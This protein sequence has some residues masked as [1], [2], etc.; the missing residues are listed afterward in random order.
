MF[1]TATQVHA[2]QVATHAPAIQAVVE[3]VFNTVDERDWAACQALFT[4]TVTADYKSLSGQPAISLPAATLIAGWKQVLPGF[5]GTQ[6]MLSNFRTRIL[7]E[8]TA[9]VRFYGQAFHFLPNSKGE[10]VWT[11]VGNYRAEVV[12]RQGKWLVRAIQF[13]LLFQSGNLGLPA[14]AAERVKNHN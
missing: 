2:Q 3:G 4:D 13:N 5:V 9:E 8:A 12:H 10:S 6:H 11:V 1:F 7:D 14:L